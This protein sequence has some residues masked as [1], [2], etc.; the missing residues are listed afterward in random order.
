MQRTGASVLVSESA[1]LVLVDHGDAFGSYSLFA[2]DAVAEGP[3]Y[4]VGGLVWTDL[5][6]RIEGESP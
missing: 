1:N 5:L 6:D 2:L 4:E 3:R